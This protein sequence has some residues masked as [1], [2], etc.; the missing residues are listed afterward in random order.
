[1]ADWIIPDHTPY[2]RA[3]LWWDGIDWRPGT[4]DAAGHPQ[5]DVLTSGLPAG[6]ATAANQ[7]T[8]ITALQLIDDL[9]NA[10]QSV[11]T[12]AIQARGENQLFSYREPLVAVGNL[13][14]PGAGDYNVDLAGCTAGQ[15]WV[16]TTIMAINTVS[17]CTWIGL[18]NRTG[19]V[20]YFLKR[21]DSPTITEGISWAGHT[22]LE[23]PDFI[24]ARF[25]GCGG[26]DNLSV[27]VTG[28]RMNKE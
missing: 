15:V 22:Y 6:A 20:S 10:L 26:A 28:Y 23:N 2:P 8:M 5:I 9:R 4:I 14:T 17:V 21:D 27:Y 18:I 11:N 24:R 16:V 12:D 1:M 13:V 19:A 25:I 7:A 3:C